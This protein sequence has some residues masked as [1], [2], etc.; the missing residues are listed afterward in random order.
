M[1]RLLGA[2]L[3]LAGLGSLGMLRAAA[4]ERR[5]Q[6]LMELRRALS[7]LR[8]SVAH[9]RLPAAVAF[10]AAGRACGGLVAQSLQEAAALLESG[11][12]AFSAGEAWWAAYRRRA[13]ESFL[14]AV[15]RAVL[16]DFCRQFGRVDAA[17]QLGG[18]DAALD[19]LAHS[20]EQA[21]G[22]RERFGRLFRFSGLAAGLGIVILL[23]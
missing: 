12:A 8:S 21:A 17:T 7:L 9:L 23:L 3:V 5:V 15:D 13:D 10:R 22:E 1:V 14:A 2:A 19:R 16:Q 6:E 18:F 4:L 20:L 11:E